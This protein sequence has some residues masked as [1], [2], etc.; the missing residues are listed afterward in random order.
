MGK[1]KLAKGFVAEI[2]ADLCVLNLAIQCILQKPQRTLGIEGIN[3]T[4]L[5][6]NVDYV[7]DG[8][9]IK[10]ISRLF[11]KGFLGVQ[12]QTVAMGIQKT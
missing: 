6:R 11:K 2:I 9:G 1:T 5:H 8:L 4:I 12:T 10:K 7:Q 3:T